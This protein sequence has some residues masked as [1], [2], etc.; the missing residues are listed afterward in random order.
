MEMNKAKELSYLFKRKTRYEIIL[1]Q[2]G[3][4]NP[5]HCYFRNS[6]TE[7][8]IDFWEEDKEEI[9]A[10]MQRKYAEAIKKIE[11]Y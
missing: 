4:G 8:T 6:R 10:I 5:I 11:E 3:N 1:K 7:V 2:I 9:K